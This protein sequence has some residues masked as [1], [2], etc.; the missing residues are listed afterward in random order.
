MQSITMGLRWIFMSFRYL[1]VKCR[2]RLLFVVT[3]IMAGVGHEAWADDATTPPN[4]V[5]IIA[6][7]LGWGDVGFHDGVARTPNLDTMAK[8]GIELNRF[9]VQP[10]CSPTRAALLTGRSPIDVG[11]TQPVGGEQPGLSLHEHLMPESFGDAGYQTALVGKWHL[12]GGRREG[13][14]YLPHHRGFDH[15]YGHV[16]GGIDYYTHAPGGRDRIDWQRNGQTIDEPGYSTDLIADE[17]VRLIEGR[18]ASR[19]LLLVVSFNAVHTPL[20][21]PQDLIDGYAGK[22]NEQARTYYAMIEAM[23]RGVGRVIAAIDEAGMT[24]NTLVMF[25]SDNGPARSVDASSTG[26]L[27]GAKGSVLEGGVRVP[28]LM[29]WPGVLPAGEVREQV[30]YVEDVFPTFAGLADV[31]PGN[32]EPLAGIDLWPALRDDR[33]VP[34]RI[35]R[36]LSKRGASVT[37][38]RWKLVSIRRGQHTTTALYDLQGD[39]NETLDL[40]E[41]HP[42]I[43]ARLKKLMP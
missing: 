4:I 35:R 1:G 7:D 16:G 37:D 30:A 25:F 18:D 2:L 42:A 13:D 5:L 17:A 9:Y 15:F 33:S 10:L 31:T 3:W 19:P 36:V 20:S 23:D 34:T 32:S 43:V 27:N 24:R 11:V 12:G 22:G 41:E 26:P 40:A 21:A 28:A 39:P 6:D 29:V 8:R 38:G 14:E